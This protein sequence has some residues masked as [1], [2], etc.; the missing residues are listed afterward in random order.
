MHTGLLEQCSKIDLDLTKLSGIT[1][2]GAIFMI[3]V[4]LGLVTLLKEHLGRYN[5][6]LI[7]FQCIIQ[8]GELVS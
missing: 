7:Q 1:T 8:Q 2:D 3:G 5:G 6:E 4:N